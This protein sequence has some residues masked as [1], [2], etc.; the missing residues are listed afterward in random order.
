MVPDPAY[1][2]ALQYLHR[3]IK[4][5]RLALAH[6]EQKGNSEREANDLADKLEALIYLYNLATNQ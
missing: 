5:T 3:H 4:K 1:E 2:K 6:T